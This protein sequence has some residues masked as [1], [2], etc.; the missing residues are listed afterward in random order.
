[1]DWKNFLGWWLI[2]EAII[3]GWND[4]VINKIHRREKFMI[5]LFTSL[6]FTMLYV[7][8]YFVCH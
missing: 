7:G 1:M 6:W 5:I 4:L 2:C 8:F 3:I